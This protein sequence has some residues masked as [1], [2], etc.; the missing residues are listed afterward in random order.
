MNNTNDYS[1]KYFGFYI[2][3]DLKVSQI[4]K[5]SQKLLSIK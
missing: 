3:N 2:N 1:K 4:K 5:I